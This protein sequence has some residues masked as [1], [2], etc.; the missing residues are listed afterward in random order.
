MNRLKK[1]LW[2]GIAVIFVNSAYPD[3]PNKNIIDY[4][5]ISVIL[6]SFYLHNVTNFNYRSKK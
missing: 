1:I 4:I 2:I 6:V 5:A 3:Y